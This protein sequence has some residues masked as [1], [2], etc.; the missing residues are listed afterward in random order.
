MS[1]LVRMHFIDCSISE[2]VG[3]GRRGVCV[4]FGLAPHI[5]PVS[6]SF[7][8]VC[9]EVAFWRKVKRCC[10][11]ESG[12]VDHRCDICLVVFF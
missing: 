5:A 8:Y 1:A 2:L 9:S 10:W 6:A 12:K 7:D 4:A 3:R 11:A